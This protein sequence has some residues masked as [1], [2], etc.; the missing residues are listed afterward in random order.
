VEVAKFDLDGPENVGAP[1]QV[2]GGSVNAVFFAGNCLEVW[3]G[4]GPG[5]T[6]N[7]F[8]EVHGESMVRAL[9]AVI[10]DTYCTEPGLDLVQLEGL[11]DRCDAELLD[12]AEGGG[13]FATQ[14]AVHGCAVVLDGRGLAV[15]VVVDQVGRE[16]LGQIIKV[17]GPEGTCHEH[18][19]EFG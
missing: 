17:R 15:C 6:V 5:S 4:V 13:R 18:R 19:H 3:F 9:D 10:D 8:A 2:F 14:D 7:V 11:V 12:F 16:A 1:G